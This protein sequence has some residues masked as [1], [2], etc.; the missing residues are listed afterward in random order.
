MTYRIDAAIDA[1]QLAGG[2][3][4]RDCARREAKGNQLRVRYD[5]MLPSSDDRNARSRV[6]MATFGRM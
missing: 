1:M 5:A 2:D 3:P 4:V 6:E